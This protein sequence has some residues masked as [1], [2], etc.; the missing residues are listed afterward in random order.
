MS[1]KCPRRLAL[2]T[3]LTPVFLCLGT[4]SAQAAQAPAAPAAASR[5][6]VGD[7]AEQLNA[8][9][10]PDDLKAKVPAAETAYI[11]SGHATRFVRPDVFFKR[12]RESSAQD[13]TAYLAALHSAEDAVDFKPGRDKPS[14]SMDKSAPEYN[15]WR[16]RRPEVL[17]PKRA[18]GPIQLSQYLGGR[19]AGGIPTFA[20][21]PV[22]FTPADLKAGKIEIAIVGAP[23]DMGTGYRDALH[24]PVALR[25]QGGTGNDMYTMINPTADL[26][27]VDYGDIAV[28]NINTDRSVE[29][30]REVV[31]EIAEAGVIPVVVGG[32]HSL[33]YPNVAGITDVHGKGKVGVVHFDSHYD[34]QHNAV[35]LLDHGQPVYRV[36]MEGHVP[37]KNYIQVGLRARIPNVE[38]F[39]WMRD[40][41]MKY[42]T[43]VEVEKHG[44]D[45]V[46]ERAVAEAKAGVDKLW[47]S[48]DI[49]VLDPAF[50]PGTGTPVPGG[51]TMRE[52]QPIVRRLCAENNMVGFDL[53]EVAPYLDTSYKTA[54]NSNY[55]L[56]ACLTG[57]AMRKRGITEPHY[58]SPLSV[59]HNQD[60]YYKDKK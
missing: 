58:L 5:A 21:A 20:N 48:F 37:G 41:G 26:R 47:V 45:A 51:L 28:D 7:T 38:D 49:D 17:D 10:I 16:T 36:I 2:S 34:V 55:I 13:I 27:I 46:M 39:N 42:H 35:H 15:A 56:N 11:E 24:G 4:W 33:E 57:I 30:V 8:V 22:A 3:V 52:A 25:A 6:M 1:H 53:V 29:H 44:W 19:S 12:L 32:D 59:D 54:L 43:M 23:L 60:N 40:H 18:P 9:Q 31:R 14:I 50:M